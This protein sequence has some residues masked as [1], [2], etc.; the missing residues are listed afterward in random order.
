MSSFYKKK[1]TKGKEEEE[2]M[3]RKGR[4]V[5]KK[6]EG[7]RGGK[8]KEGKEKEKEEEEMT[9]INANDRTWT[10]RFFF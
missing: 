8:E 3:D 10:K 4:R 9:I 6:G 5:E 7:N 1:K 2:W